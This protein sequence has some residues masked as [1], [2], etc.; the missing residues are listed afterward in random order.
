MKVNFTATITQEEKSSLQ[1]VIDMLSK[2]TDGE[3]LMISECLKAYGY[4]SLDDVRDTLITLRE[5]SEVEQC[6]KMF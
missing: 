5:W 4:C 2:L 3:S 1:A 6:Q